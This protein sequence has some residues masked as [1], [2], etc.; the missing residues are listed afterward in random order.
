MKS[1]PQIIGELLERDLFCPYEVLQAYH[2]ELT[3]NG[4]MLCPV[5]AMIAAGLIVERVTLAENGEPQ[6]KPRLN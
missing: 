4:W 1:V 6:D 3:A 5:G 2:D